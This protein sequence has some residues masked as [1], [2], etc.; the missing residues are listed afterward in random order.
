MAPLLHA[1]FYANITDDVDNHWEI[2]HSGKNVSETIKDW[3]VK[4]VGEPINQMLRYCQ[5]FSFFIS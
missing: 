5:S 4:Y 2:T 3:L 1:D